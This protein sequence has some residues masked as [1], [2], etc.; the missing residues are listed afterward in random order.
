[1]GWIKSTILSSVPGLVHGFGDRSVSSDP[2]GIAAYFG[3]S[4]IARLNQVHGRDVFLLLDEALNGGGKLADADAIVTAL[5][6]V[7][8]GVASA[9][10]V[11]I[12][13]ADNEGHIA[14]AVHAGWR[15]TLARILDAALEK[16]DEEYGLKAA[17]LNAAIGPSIKKCCYEVGDDV[18]SLFMGRFDDWSEYLV[19]AGNFKYFLDLPGA[20]RN[21][22]ERSGLA[23]IEVIDIC[24]KCDPEFYSY[25]REGKGVGSQLSV[26][27]LV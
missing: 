3:L 14:A 18:A 1:M 5:R 24:T 16:I 15:G 10:C 17:D 8:I 21:E 11:P 26:I 20:N 19:P 22:L 27:G 9:D 23:N 4:G 7:G 12:L 2:A 13:L 6:G 25:R